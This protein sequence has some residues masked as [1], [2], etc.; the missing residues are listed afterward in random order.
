MH[1]TLKQMGAQKKRQK[2]PGSLVTLTTNRGTAQPQ[3]WN[4]IMHELALSEVLDFFRWLVL[5]IAHLFGP[6]ILEFGNVKPDFWVL[7]KYGKER[8][9]V[10][11]QN[12]SLV[13]F[14]G[15]S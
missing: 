8:D 10:K 15:F 2:I 7:E 14:K 5:C 12:D 1:E 6:M 13:I 4:E 11:L 9:L 3:A